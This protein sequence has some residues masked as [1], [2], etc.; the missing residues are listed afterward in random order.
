MTKRVFGISLHWM[1][2]SRCLKASAWNFA[3]PCLHKTV[4]QRPEKNACDSLLPPPPNLWQIFDVGLSLKSHEQ[5]LS[6]CT[7]T[8]SLWKEWNA[9]YFICNMNGY[10]YQSPIPEFVGSYTLTPLTMWFGPCEVVLYARDK[11]YKKLSEFASFP[12]NFFSVLL[13]TMVSGGMC[14]HKS[15]QSCSW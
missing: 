7:C 2:A 3:L 10:F 8:T 11:H 13:T 1:Y 5:P 12:E 6:F 15:R 4:Y 14:V 9:K